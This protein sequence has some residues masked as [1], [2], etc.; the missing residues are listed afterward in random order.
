M[1]AALLDARQ[2]MAKRVRD[3]SKSLS[4]RQ[5][6]LVSRMLQT[7]LDRLPIE[8]TKLE[9]DMVDAQFDEAFRDGT[10]PTMWIFNIWKYQI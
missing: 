6:E 10:A 9:P 5:Q 4:P 2:D 8:P 7:A 1:D 3:H